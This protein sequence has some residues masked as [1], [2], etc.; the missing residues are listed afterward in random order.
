MAQQHSVAAL[1]PFELIPVQR[2]RVAKAAQQPAQVC[3]ACAHCALQAKLALCTAQM[4]V[5]P[6]KLKHAHASMH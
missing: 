3:M 1:Q 2:R 5:L 4:A 6:L